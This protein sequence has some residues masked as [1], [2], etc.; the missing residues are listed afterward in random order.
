[1][2][3]FLQMSLWGGVLTAVILALRSFFGGKL[4]KKAFRALWAV[5]VLRM[6]VPI[7]LPVVKVDT[8]VSAKTAFSGDMSVCTYVN[9]E[10]TQTADEITAYTVTEGT[11]DG[12]PLTEIWLFTALAIFAAFA[13]VHIKFRLNV[14]D[15][16]LI[17]ILETGR[18]KVRLKVSDRIGSPLTYGVLRPV[19]LLPK[20]IFDCGEKAAEYVLAHE[21]THI[22]RFDVLF[23]LLAVLAASLHWFNPFAW[24]M[25]AFAN[26]DIELSCDEE[27]ILGNGGSREEYALT[28]IEMEEKRSFG[29]LQSG[30]GESSVKERIRAVM[31]A[32]KASAAG[33]IF[34]AALTLTAFA[35]FTVYDI[36]ALGYGVTVTENGA[37]EVYAYYYDPLSEG[38]Y[39]D[40]A[41][42]EI[43]VEEAPAVYAEVEVTAAEPWDMYSYTISVVDYDGVKLYRVETED[44]VYAVPA[45]EV[46]RSI[47][48][49][50]T[51]R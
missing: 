17:K 21:I 11:A 14:R 51:S 12:L 48:A 34:A 35:V 20:N 22:K 5:V 9:G 15:A 31:T 32:K 16:I 45:E 2:I 28:L 36:D 13:L 37:G 47:L 44:L 27:V 33:K 50:S 49:D 43:A 18:R 8:P 25:L 26:R 38:T 39:E 29:V 41:V 46:L 1:M 7:S 4:P 24:A 10:F 42:Y 19:I 30:F 6:L 40:D 23:K 3:S